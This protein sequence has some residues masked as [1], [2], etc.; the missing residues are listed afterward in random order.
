MNRPVFTAIPGHNP[1]S[2]ESANTSAFGTMP[3]GDGIGVLLVVSD[4]G[5]RASPAAIRLANALSSDHRSSS[6]MLS[7]GIT[8]RPGGSVNKEVVFLEGTL[9]PAPWSMAL[10]PPRGSLSGQSGRCN[11]LREL[12]RIHGSTSSIRTHRRPIA[13]FSTSWTAW[14]SPGSHT[15]TV[16]PRKVTHPFSYGRCNRRPASSTI[17]RPTLDD[18]AARALV[19]TTTDRA[20]GS[21]RHRFGSFDLYSGLCRGVRAPASASPESTP[22]VTRV[23]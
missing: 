1:H 14:T 23:A 17:A 5:D 4:L 8:S 21:Y 10:D 13:W 15:S 20:A 2:S 11:I 7:L 18:A 9:G 19:R 16:R 12:I 22:R 3:A 6:A